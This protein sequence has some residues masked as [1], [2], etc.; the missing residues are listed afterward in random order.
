MDVV[1]DLAEVID[2][3][4]VADRELFR[5][6]EFAA[7]P[8]RACHGVSRRLAP[9]V[10]AASVAA[11]FAAATRRQDRLVQDFTLWTEPV[12]APSDAA[13]AI[14]RRDRELSRSVDPDRSAGRV[15]LLTYRDG[16]SD[17]VVVAH[18]A[19]ADLADLRAICG[20]LTGAAP[21]RIAAPAASE[22]GPAEPIVRQELAWGCGDPARA[23]HAG[24]VA[25]PAV[26]VRKHALEIVLAATEILL[27]RYGTEQPQIAL[28]LSTAGATHELRRIAAP[29]GDDPSIAEVLAA[30]AR[31]VRV[32]PIAGDGELAAV[33]VV[34]TENDGGDVYVPCSGPMFPLTLVWEA[35][36]D[37]RLHGSLW[38]DEGQISPAAAAQAARH[39]AAL[40]A[41]LSGGAT[42]G[43]VSDLVSLD[44]AETRQI[45]EVGRSAPRGH[46]PIATIP[47]LFDLIAA[48]QPDAPAVSDDKETLSYRELARRADQVAAGLGARGIRRGDRVGVCLDRSADLIVTM[49]GVLRAGAA[50]VPMDSHYP[51]ER[52]SFTTQD[53]GL[54]LVVSDAESFPRSGRVDVL[55][56]AAVRSLAPGRPVDPGAQPDDLAYVI[57]TSGSTGRPKGVAIPHKN[58]AVLLDATAQ[59]MALG[60]ADTWTVFHS[61]A[62]DFSVWEI[63]G[64]LL[65][66]GHLVVVSHWVSRAPDEFYDLLVARRVTVLSQTP[67]A[68]AALQAVDDRRR[69][70]LALRLV[71]FG[72]EALDVRTLAPWF[73]R[74]PGSECRMVNMFGITETTVH[75][76]HQTITPHHVRTGSRS[77]GKALPGWSVSVRDSRGRVQPFG[78]PGEIYVGG[79][80]LASHYLNRDDL[81]RTRFISDA[82]TGERL[83]RSGDLGRLHPD[84][85][86]DHLGRIDSQV[87]IRG[88]RIEL[89]EIRS[90]ILEC[91]GVEAAA[92]L[93]SRGDRADAATV[94]LDA[95]VV[96]H[97]GAKLDEIRRRAARYL[98]DYMMPSSFIPV[99]HLP[100]NSNGKLDAAALAQHK[101]AQR[102]QPAPAAPASSEEP[103]NEI[104][105]VWREVLGK[106]VAIDDDFFE[107][108]GNSL[109]AVHLLSAI[110]KLGFDSFSLRDLYKHSSPSASIAFL[111]SRRG[112][113]QANDNARSS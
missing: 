6:R 85:T 62:F 108:G 7:R 10:G 3:P 21:A 109:L 90:V 35:G 57:Y 81:T 36:A 71:V 55:T 33:G 41:R 48:R 110:R 107:S 72:G 111:A 92:V 67:S 28:L 25:I 17:L 19:R 40:I 15:V 14:A 32:P 20:V 73:R 49:L 84:G 53:A 100:I 46:L 97:A 93:V 51:Q 5:H 68:F 65:T 94:Q 70:A 103:G 82:V 2:P 105:R 29:P 42:D 102:H 101:L 23:G 18:R 56:P 79:S 43:K 38:H 22:P 8:E 78:V 113:K 64:C 86:L 61:S 39:L 63:W 89:D 112:G 87:K 54:A 9:S 58:V 16:V 26:A 88:F 12:P 50:Y 75:V 98:P 27:S 4:L 69:A 59:D 60:P 106:Q 99:T 24:R 95:Y 77:V 44:D 80:A 37:H 66:G 96:P 1:R 76:T 34:F 45:L 31:R 74:H 52:L 83:Y 104:L 47:A 91:P 13:E 30:A 11:A